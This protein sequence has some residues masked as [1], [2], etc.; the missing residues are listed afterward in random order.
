[1]Y[2]SLDIL[3]IIEE[4]LSINSMKDILETIEIF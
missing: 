3:E 1:M 4:G 2:L